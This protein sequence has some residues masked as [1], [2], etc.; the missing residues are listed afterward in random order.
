[1]L[2]GRFTTPNTRSFECRTD[3]PLAARFVA[4]KPASPGLTTGRTP[5]LDPG[6]CPAATVNRL[7]DAPDGAA[8]A[9]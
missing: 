7:S 9:G 5:A 8:A 6:A 4:A 3:S 1:M 2:I